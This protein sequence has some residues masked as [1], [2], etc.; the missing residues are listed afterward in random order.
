MK[1]LTGVAI[2]LAAVVAAGAGAQQPI[3]IQHI[4]PM[5]Q[6]GVNM[7]EPS[8]HDTVTFQ[9]TRVVF[10]G[11][12]RQDFQGLQ[13]KNTSP[14]PL[15]GLGHGFNNAVANLN[16]DVQ[17]VKG[18]RIAMTSYLSS[19]HH[20]ETWVKDGYI[21]VD[22]SP[23]DNKYLNEIM[24]HTTLKVGHFEV[25]Y[26]DGHFRR[27]DNG[28]A[29]FNPFVGN[30]ILDAFS[31]EVGAEV[32]VHDGWW[33]AMA[34]MTNGEVK[35]MV[36]A[37]EK[38]SPAYFGKVGVDGTVIKDLRVRLTASA[39]SQSSSA[40]QTLYGGDRAGSQYYSVVEPVG[41]SEAT[42]AWSGMVRNPFGSAIQGQ[43][44][45]Q[46]IK[47]KGA[48]FAGQLEWARGMNATVDTEK[49]KISQQVVEGLYRLGGREQ[50]YVGARYNNFDGE[51]VAGSKAKVNIS[52]YQTGG[53][54]FV[55][56]NLLAK[57]EWV[58]QNYGGFT[59]LRKGASFKGFMFSGAVSF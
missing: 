32:Y 34:G 19:R 22:A 33:L 1:N 27:T 9:G 5:D 23:I 58:N 25:N 41:V 18:V 14:T 54:W 50:Y 20:N 12:F 31:T 38:R 11:A 15:V 26:G 49:R 21:L 36:T 40:S 45:N 57:G 46:F 37:P 52:R 10:G 17:L 3:S 6:R 51:L 24:S 55:T 42:N 4:R 35:G 16:M 7:Y 59:D 2:V 53:G 39:I 47:Y 30:Y 29:L 44:F 13:H 28:S 8:K 43:M 56:K 48:E